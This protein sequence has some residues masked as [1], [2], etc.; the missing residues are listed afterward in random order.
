MPYRMHFFLSL[1]RV[2]LNIPKYVSFQTVIPKEKKADAHLIQVQIF[3]AASQVI[4]PQTTRF[5][6]EIAMMGQCH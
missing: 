5:F 2:E 6:S 4:P 1:L 3:T